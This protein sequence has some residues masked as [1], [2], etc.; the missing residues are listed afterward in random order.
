V[1]GSPTSLAYARASVRV[2]A[3]P[4]T[5]DPEPDCGAAINGSTS[6]FPSNKANLGPRVG[7]AYDVLG[8]GKTVLRGGYGEFFAR[9][10]NSTIYNALGQTGNAAGQL[11]ISLPNSATPVQLVDGTSIAGPLFPTI[12]NPALKP[13]GAT[14]VFYFNRNFKVPE[15]QQTDLTVAQDLGWNTT[16]EVTW[17]AAFGRRLPDFVDTNLPA[18]NGTISYTVAGSSGN[19]PIAPGTVLSFPFYGR[20]N[21]ANGRPNPNFGSTTDIFSGVN[22]NYEALVGHLVHHLAKG[23]QFD[24]NYTWSHALDYGE[25]NTTFTST[26]L[27][28]DPRNL[29]LDYGNSNQNVPN[30]LVM[31]AVYETPSPFRGILGHLLNDYE[32][33][34]SY[35]GQTGLPYSYGASGST[36]NLQIASGSG[37]SSALAAIGS[38]INGSGGANRVPGFARNFFKQP[39]TQVLDLR[40]SKK[41]DL[42]D[43]AKVELLGESFNIA[44]HLN[45]SGVNTGAYSYGGTAGTSA[46]PTPPQHPH[47]QH[48]FRHPDERQQ[49]SRLQRTAGPAWRQ[50]AV[51]NRLSG[52]LRGADLRPHI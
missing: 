43:R 2:R 31:F 15:I 8:S 25:N 21:T 12:L 23:L 50:G 42:A 10:I 36:N 39:R 44:N 26:N 45:V 46:N 34:P 48:H 52:R 51:L 49:Q 22:S 37:T 40:L 29:R 1:E 47:L 4:D 35:A 5:A 41:F 18:S 30:R 3:V 38:S 27:L 17:L 32:I 24:I 19:G 14:A 9:A 28:L 33:S 7:F 11:S 6:V 16:L 20:L 13:G